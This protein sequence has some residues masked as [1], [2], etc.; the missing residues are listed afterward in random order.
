MAVNSGHRTEDKRGTVEREHIK[1][2]MGWGAKLSNNQAAQVGRGGGCKRNRGRNEKTS[3]Q[4]RQV[5]GEFRSDIGGRPRR[6]RA[7]ASVKLLTIGKGGGPAG[8]RRLRCSES[9]RGE[10]GIVFPTRTLGGWAT[11]TVREVGSS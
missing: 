1:G 5:R 9:L 4:Q 2:N 3:R 6:S 7:L 11:D 8:E 10:M